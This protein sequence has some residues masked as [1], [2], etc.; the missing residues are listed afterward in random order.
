MSGIA[1]AQPSGALIVPA[2]GALRGMEELRGATR[3]PQSLILSREEP[4]GVT[5]IIGGT[6]VRFCLS[7]VRDSEPIT[8]AVKW[9]ELNEQ[10]APG[11]ESRGIK[12]EHAKDVVIA[13]IARQFVDYVE[14]QFDPL[15]GPPPFDQISAAV[16]SVAGRV[17][18]E[19]A[20]ALITTTNTGI[21][22]TKEP[23]ART[24]LA[25]INEEIRFRNKE[26]A[27]R[28]DPQWSTVDTS[29]VKVLNDA[30]AGLRGEMIL[31]GLQNCETGGFVIVG[32]GLG[33]MV[34]INGQ[35]SYLYCEFGHLV[36]QETAQ[37]KTRYRLLT[38]LEFDQC[39]TEEG[40]YKAPK[41]NQK[42]FE[43]I[44]AGPWL[45]IRFLRE[46]SKEGSE[47]LLLALAQVCSKTLKQDEELCRKH[48]NLEPED[49]V[50]QFTSL[51][52]LP[53]T[54]RHRWAI[55]LPSHLVRAVNQFILCPTPEGLWTALAC[56][57]RFEE[58]PF[59]NPMAALVFKG[60]RAWKAYFKDLGAGLG[61][62]YRDMKQKGIAPQKLII[63][64]GIGEA[65]ARYNDFMREDALR[66]IRTFGKFPKDVVEFSRV[67]PEARE[68][69]LAY[70][71]NRA[72]YDR[73]PEKKA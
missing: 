9:Q 53:S 29:V 7:H 31:G 67:S 61:V 11:L 47:P 17:E 16:F 39:L 51:A 66:L 34:L 1:S 56:E 21:N 50:A 26:L 64:G 30:D 55:N 5:I 3:D 68:G 60:A 54:E 20:D 42:Y 35:P 45:A 22:L 33:G 71:L 36:V 59:V 10:L 63:G 6:N 57:P 15:E 32:T 43:T 38:K 62:I 48:P 40:S 4:F 73:L 2:I 14:S 28:G 18:G 12:F 65:C 58:A 24:M 72:A 44:V 41:G 27:E 46:L 49:L 69:A 23:I 19:D 70:L 13:E 8:S 25:A 37:N 52:E